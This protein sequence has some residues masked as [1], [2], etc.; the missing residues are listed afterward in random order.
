MPMTL[1]WDW[2]DMTGGYTGFDD[3][4]A[5]NGLAANGVLNDIPALPSRF[6]GQNNGGPAGL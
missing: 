1:D 3:P 5:A 2:A 6:D 4:N